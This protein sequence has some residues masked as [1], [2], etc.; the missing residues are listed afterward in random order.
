MQSNSCIYTHIRILHENLSNDLKLDVRILMFCY[1]V[2]VPMFIFMY[3]ILLLSGKSHT[4]TNSIPKGDERKGPS[5]EK[6]GTSPTDEQWFQRETR[7]R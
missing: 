2:A 1:P 3:Y 4:P 6:S 5:S 7:G